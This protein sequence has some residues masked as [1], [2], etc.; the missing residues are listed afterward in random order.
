[1]KINVILIIVLLS[2]AGC[3]WFENTPSF[4]DDFITYKISKGNHEIDN[5]SNGLFTAS[6]LKFQ[7]I[8]D[9][10]CIYQTTDA[11]N[12]YDINKLVGFSDC[13]SLH[14]QNSARFGWNWRENALNIY[15]YIYVD[16]QRQE[17]QLG[18]LALGQKGSFKL[19]T[20]NN[21]YI[22]TFNGAQTIM[23]RHCADGRGVSYKLL[24]YFGGDEVAP[25]DMYIKIR[26]I[27]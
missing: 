9:S 7:A 20:L 11:G 2:L 5:N 14:H 24:P 26:Y 10:T 3:Q 21:T 13:N 17:Q 6:E 8:F 1:M 16:G 22:F 27:E 15:A 12:Q 23:P 19:T 18:T 4:G 25:H